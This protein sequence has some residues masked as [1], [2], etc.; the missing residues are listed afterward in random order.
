MADDW[1]VGRTA[2]LAL[3][4]GLVGAL[5]AVEGALAAVGQLPLLGAGSCRPG[6]GREDLARLRRGLARGASVVDLGPLPDAEV[7]ELVGGRPGRGLAGL[8]SRA[9][10]NPLYARELADGLVREG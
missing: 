4:D 5:R 3:L 6:A 9:G 2:E 1:F 8:V 7:G 10:G